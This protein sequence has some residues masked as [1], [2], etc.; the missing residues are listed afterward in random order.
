MDQNVMRIPVGTM[1]RQAWRAN[2]IGTLNHQATLVQV[3]KDQNGGMN[4][5]ASKHRLVMDQTGKIRKKKMTNATGKTILKAAA[6]HSM[7]RMLAITSLYVSMPVMMSKLAFTKLQTSSVLKG[8][9]LVKM[10][11]NLEDQCDDSN[12]LSVDFQLPLKVDISKH[13][14][15]FVSLNLI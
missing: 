15:A 10:K 13:L 9:T 2:L 3:L 6:T 14:G 12:E 8:N 11:E 5:Q 7:A 4:H 1:N